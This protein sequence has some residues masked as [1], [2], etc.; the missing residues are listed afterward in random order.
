MV[1]GWD[2]KWLASKAVLDGA[3]NVDVCCLMF[4]LL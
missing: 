1:L 2:A 4:A 3:F